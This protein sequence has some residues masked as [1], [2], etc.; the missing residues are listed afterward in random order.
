MR[1]PFI[2]QSTEDSLASSQ[3]F[4][5][6][7]FYQKFL[8]DVSHCRRELL[9]ESPFLTVRRTNF[10]LPTL[11]GLRS[12]GVNII[13]NTRH[14]N[15]HE[16]FLKSEAE[17]SI[18]LLQSIGISVLATGG[19]HRKIAIVDRRVL[20]EGSLN[21]LSHNTSCEMMRR[22]DSHSMSQDMIRFLNATSKVVT[23]ATII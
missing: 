2:H 21:I 10:F 19:L 1:I 22:I 18:A 3:L 6:K 14:P 7:A 17:Q 16:G 13:V 9:L 4:N 23:N 12:R 11:Q 15:E 20:W 8:K 5:E